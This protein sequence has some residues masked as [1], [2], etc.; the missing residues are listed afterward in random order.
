[1]S[2]V[3][4]WTNLSMG[5]YMPAGVCWF[6][7][8]LEVVSLKTQHWHPVTRERLPFFLNQPYP[9][10]EETSNCSSALTTILSKMLRSFITSR[11]S[12]VILKKREGEAGE[13]FCPRLQMSEGSRGTVMFYMGYSAH[14]SAELGQLLCLQ[15]KIALQG[16]FCE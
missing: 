5:N 14:S 15:Q 6:A 10:A 1:M 7:W 16:W 2:R 12:Q 9:F 3:P 8:L 4:E 11:I 13:F